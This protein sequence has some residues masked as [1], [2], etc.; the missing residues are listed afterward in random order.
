MCWRALHNE[1]SF[2]LHTSIILKAITGIRSAPLWDSVLHDYVG[3]ITVSD[4]I[5]ILLHFNK[6][7]SNNDSI[8]EDLA[9]HK[10]RTWRGK[11]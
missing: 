7:P 10:I 9:N 2:S 1:T 8:F 3:M 4:F 6:D 5:D 11:H